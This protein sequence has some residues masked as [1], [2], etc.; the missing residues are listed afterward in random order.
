[1]ADDALTAPLLS[2]RAPDGRIVA[3][4]LAGDRMVDVARAAAALG[5]AVTVDDQAPGLHALLGAWDA[6]RPA[7]AALQAQLIAGEAQAPWDLGAFAAGDERVV[8]PVPRPEKLLFAGANYQ[9]HVLEDAARFDPDT[10][11]AAAA[12][13][14][15]PYMFI[16]LPLCVSGP[17]A[18]IVR[19]LGHDQL[20]YE[21]E[22]AVVIGRGGR[23]V[24]PEDALDHVAGYL[25]CNDVSSRSRTMRADW[26]FLKTDWFS[27]K[28]FETAAPLGP[29]LLPA[30]AVPDWRAL[31]LRL[32]VNGELRQNDRAGEMTFGIE[33]QIA[34]ASRQVPLR[35]GDVI[36]TGTPAGS[37]FRDGRYLQPGDV[38]EAGGDGLGAQ[39]TAV[40]AEAPAALA[41]RPS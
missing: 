12:E 9:R 23:H 2:V 19:P 30:A 24:E 16:K 25:L 1:M 11:G 37:G 6:N 31:R 21:V 33:E 29:F 22:L 17:Y 4:L 36:A 10:A 39:R 14:A 28:N 38:V 5:I 26:P 3:A 35:P 8:A 7:L 40:R 15:E 27:G 13:A 18:P 34:F 32:W 41:A 20:D